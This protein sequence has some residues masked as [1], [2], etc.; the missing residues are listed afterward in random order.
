[1]KG[2]AMAAREFPPS[3]ALELA[4]KDAELV[5]EAADRHD[6]ELPLIEAVARQMRRATEAG[7]GREDMAATVRASLPPG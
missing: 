1:M 7:H 5:R 4:L 3:F 2:E 6:L